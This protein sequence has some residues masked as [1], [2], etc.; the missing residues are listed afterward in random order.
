MW[1]QTTDG[2]SLFVYQWR[3]TAESAPR[4]V[5]QLLHGASEHARR[6]ERLAHALTAAGYLVY[7]HDQRGHGQTAGSLERLGNANADGWHWLV[8][9]ARRVSELIRRLHPDLPLFLL[10]HSMG[11]ALAQ[12]YLQ[13]WSADLHGVILSGPG[14]PALDLE[15]VIALA[16]QAAQADPHAPSVVASQMFAALNAPFAPGKTGF[17]WLSRD[18]DEVQAYVNDP[19]CGFPFGNRLAADLFAGLHCLW[20]PENLAK[21]PRHLPLLVL[22]G[23]NDP[24]GGN[25]VGVQA[26]LDQYAGLGMKELSHRFYAGARHEVFNERNRA[27]VHCDLVTWLNAHL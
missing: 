9:D 25:T 7:A 26:L 11:A 18:E 21:L 8:Q 14:G 15:P 3:P 16:E 12:R 1:L 23:G 17:E 20:Q 13:Q 24:V 10:G 22:A 5:V 6:Y 19:W 27:E 4:A 2:F